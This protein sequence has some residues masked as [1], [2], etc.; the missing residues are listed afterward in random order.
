MGGRRTLNPSNLLSRHEL[1]WG[2]MSLMPMHPHGNIVFVIIYHLNRLEA[3]V[4]SIRPHIS[5]SIP[6]WFPCMFTCACK[7]S[8]CHLITLEAYSTLFD[9][10][11]LGSY[12]NT[13]PSPHAFG[14]EL[15]FTSVDDD[16]DDASLHNLAKHSCISK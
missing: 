11:H 3:R 1:K 10:E 8:S 5:F 13:T 2:P 6:I 4:F 15:H 9:G 14:C 12:G 16:D 7:C